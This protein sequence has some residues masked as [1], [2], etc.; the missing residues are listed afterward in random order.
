MATPAATKQK[1]KPSRPN[2]VQALQAIDKLPG[3]QPQQGQGGIPQPAPFP[4]PSSQL[5]RTRPGVPNLTDMVLRS[6]QPAQAAQ[7]QGQ[8][9]M[10]ADPNQQAAQTTN[11]RS[12]P[13]M[14]ARTQGMQPKRGFAQPAPQGR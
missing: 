8:A 4:Y 14:S 5:D 9:P 6:F 10:Q 7:P 12:A 3:V 2:R 1:W 11:P 13:P